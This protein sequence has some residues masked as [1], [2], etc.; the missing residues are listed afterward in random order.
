MANLILVGLGGI[1]GSF[2]RFYLGTYIAKKYSHSFPLA[3]LLI[4]I[5]GSFILAFLAFYEPLKTSYYSESLKYFLMTGFLGAYTTFSTFSVE[6]F[7]FL[8]DKAYTNLLVY[9]L[10]TLFVG[11]L[12]AYLGATLGKTL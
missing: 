7:Q 8:E 4:N 1:L 10:G 6:S 11:L 2:S 3:T 12:A 5:S 9:I